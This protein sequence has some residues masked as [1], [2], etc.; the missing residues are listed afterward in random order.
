M[1]LSKQVIY[2]EL[3]KRLKEL[4][5]KQESLFYWVKEVTTKGDNYFVAYLYGVSDTKRRFIN[6]QCSAFTVAELG[7]LLPF[8][9]ST[10][11]KEKK[12]ASDCSGTPGSSSFPRAKQINTGHNGSHDTPRPS[13][14][15]RCP[16]RLRAG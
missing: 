12:E 13:H 2:L 9:V 11:A 10:K 15:R 14:P 4:G 3:Y 7:I 6:I 1:Q 5:V 8:S 16:C